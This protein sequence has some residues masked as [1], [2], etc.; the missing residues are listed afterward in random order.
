MEVKII[1]SPNRKKTIQA[2]MV[3]ETLEVHLPLGMNPEEERKAIEEMKQKIEKRRLKRKINEDDY[4]GKRFDEF[5]KKY[6]QGKLKINSIK[7]VTNQEKQRGSCTPGNA[8]IRISHKLLGMPEWVLDYLIM[9]EMTHLV[10]PDHSKAFWEK[11][12]EYKYTERARGFLIAKEME[13]ND[14]DRNGSEV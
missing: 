13:K 9:H 12:G 2:R 14:S 1:R 4:L 8:T 5:N 3:G 10:H 11:V 6:F 7:F